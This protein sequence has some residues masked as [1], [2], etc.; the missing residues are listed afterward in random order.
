MDGIIKKKRKSCAY[1]YQCLR[2]HQGYTVYAMKARKWLS[3]GIY[4]QNQNDL[5]PHQNAT[6]YYLIFAITT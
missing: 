5:F 1:K 6:A 4:C 3:N 2:K